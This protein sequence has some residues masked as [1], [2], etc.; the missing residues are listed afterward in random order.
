V[1]AF[2]PPEAT[3]ARRTLLY[4][5]VIAIAMFAGITFFATNLHILPSEDETVVSQIARTVFGSNALWYFIQIVT[6]LILVLAANTA[7]ADFPRLSYFLARDK[8][9]PH[10]YSFRGDRLAYSWGIVTLAA[11]ACILIIVFN[12][13]TSALIPLYAIGVMSAFTFSQTG[14]VVR[15]WRTRPRGWQRNLILNAVGATVTALVFVTATFTKLDKGTWLVLILVPV[16]IAMFLAINRHYRRLAAEV[17]SAVIPRRREFTHTFIVPV[18]SLNAVSL[19]ALD[20]ARS[21]STNVTAVHIAEGEDEEEAVEFNKRWKATMEPT[22]INLVIIESPYRSLI[23]PLLSYI[24]ALD[25]Q[26]A[27]DTI[28]IVLP[29]FLPA[30]PWEYLLHNQSALRL[31]AAL[32]FRPNTIVADVPYQLGRNASPRVQRAQAQLRTFPWGAI[33]SLALLLAIALLYYFLVFIK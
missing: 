9:M 21:L 14:M 13:E 29:E 30:K 17:S 12:G 11:L 32:L 7:F 10:Q 24:D 19:E 16:L 5:G 8:F 23:A 3:N 1:P 15:W 25:R 27:D 26:V 6:A 20:Y 18:S 4:M 33:V 22:D 28:T 31:K 2:K